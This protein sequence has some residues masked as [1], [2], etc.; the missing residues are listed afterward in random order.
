MGASIGVTV[1]AVLAAAF[2]PTRGPDPDP[3]I[4]TKIHLLQ[5]SAASQSYHSAYGFWPTGYA[6]FYPEHN[7]NHIAFLPSEAWT[8]N[9]AWGHPLLYTPF[10][11]GINY[12]AVVSLG[13]D[14]KRGGARADSDLEE[15]F[16]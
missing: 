14:G 16:Q 1:L 6:E 7:V 9:D 11:P 12:G 5:I 8:T 2:R 10:D 4:T 15:R 3:A 13:H